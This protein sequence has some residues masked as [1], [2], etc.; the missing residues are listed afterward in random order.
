M[1]D[2]SSRFERF[3]LKYQLPEHLASE[4]R[5]S[6]RPYCLPDKHNKSDSSGYLI[7]SLYLDTP[8][9]AFH[10]AKLRDDPNRFKLRIR[11]YDDFGPAQF[12]IKRKV[13][14]VIAKQRVAIPRDQVEI[15]LLGE[16]SP[17]KASETNDLY[18]DEFVRLKY[19]TGAEPVILV[20]YER[21]AYVSQLDRYARITFD[22][23][24]SYQGRT[25]CDL[26]G[27]EK[28]WTP[29]D[30]YWQYDG[31]Q[32]AFTFEIKCEQKVPYWISDIIRRYNL[33]LI[34]Y[35]KYSLSISNLLRQQAGLGAYAYV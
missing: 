21:E 30:G 22:R 7:K 29:I 31:M 11:T 9:L 34:G 32:S 20:Q 14:E 10:R 4:L 12:E 13:K 17:L 3:E 25:S 26:I 8:T 28:E 16:G 1:L 6:I 5:T 18:L 35:S 23:K 33:N 19:L 2:F 24:I 27:S 15:A